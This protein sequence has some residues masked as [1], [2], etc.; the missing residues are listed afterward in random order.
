MVLTFT[1]L[2]TKE[3]GLFQE[4]NATPLALQ[5]RRERLIVLGN[6]IEG[7]K[8]HLHPGQREEQL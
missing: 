7:Q 1:E 3:E 4:S 6:L 5:G 8:R 2:T